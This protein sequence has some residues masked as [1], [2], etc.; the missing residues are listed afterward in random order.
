MKNLLTRIALALLITQGPGVAN[1][2]DAN[3]SESLEIQFLADESAQLRNKA[4]E[5]SGPVQIFEYVRN[6]VEFLPY[7]GAKSGSI[8]TFLG[9][10]GN[11]VDT[12]SVLIAM[13]RSRGIPARYAVGTIRMP[14]TDAANWL[15][16]KNVDLAKSI[17]RDQG[18]QFVTLATDQSTIELEHVWVEALLPFDNYRGESNAD[19]QALCQ[20][21]P[22]GCTWVGLSPS[23]KRHKWVDNP[24]RLH[25][26]LAFD[27]TKYYEAIKNKDDTRRDK[28]PLE[29]YE[30][31]I[32]EYLRA[33]HQ[34]KS[35]DDAIENK[36]I[37]REELGLL[38]ASLPFTTV[39]AIRRYDAMSD[40][41][42]AAPSSERKKWAKTLHVTTGL[43]YGQCSE[44]LGTFDVNL[45]ELATR[46]LTS[47][48][49]L[50]SSASKLQQI[51]RLGGNAIP[52]M[53]FDMGALYAS[54]LSGVFGGTPPENVVYTF[55]CSNDGARLAID[56]SKK[57]SKQTPIKIELR[58]EGPPDPDGGANDMSTTATY[59]GI[60]GGYYLIATGGESS[61]WTQSHRAAE[62]LLNANARY[63]VVFNPSDL[64]NPT[65]QPDTGIDC[66][67][68]IDANGN[69]WDA[70]DKKLMDDTAAQDELT[71]G[72]LY[73]AGTQYFTKM[74]E[75]LAR[76]D[77]LNRVK[78]PI[79]N[80]LGVVSTVDDVEYIDGT[81]FSVLPGG[82]LIDMKGIHIL[83]SWKI[84]D[85]GSFSNKQF[86]L[87]G[88]IGSSL[89]HEIW[90]ELTG[91]DAVSTVRGIQMALANGA[92]LLN[93]KKNAATDNVA[94]EL[95]KMGFS[96][97]VPAGF[98]AVNFDLYGDKPTAWTHA[99]VGKSFEYFR[100]GVS[101][102]TPTYYRTWGTY[103]YST[104]SGLYGWTKCADDY[105]NYFIAN[106]SKYIFGPLSYCDGT[107]L[108]SGSNIFSTGTALLYK[109]EEIWKSPS[110]SLDQ[111]LIELAIGQNVY[112]FFD[113]NKGF[114]VG[115][116]LYRTIPLAADAFPLSN[117]V[118]FR[119]DVLV[120]DVAQSWVEYLI[121]SKLTTGS[122]YRFA[123]DIRKQY[124]SSTGHLASM[125]MAISNNSLTAGG[126][127]VGQGLPSAPRSATEPNPTEGN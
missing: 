96:S 47:G 103:T 116:N 77:S 114:V 106:S 29:I 108:L 30:A 97:S 11:D 41:D 110:F 26:A 80:F 92:T 102:S 115:N 101:A 63:P 74:R 52:G 27:Y 39:S 93:P 10:R 104:N 31:Q 111:S 88:H 5:L 127:Y 121:P 98:A 117:V 61:N 38:P 99:T 79:A 60:A 95:V 105:E 113:R 109:T 13:L 32:L 50:D 25:D 66:I 37:E 71:G 35:I 73:V 49:L 68:Y 87:F 36:G 4:A 21:N 55:V 12:A 76:L 3:L 84:D 118:F 23:F 18:I 100:P 91:Y 34:G 22:S 65:C 17:L 86:E 2:L 33:N 14:A 107:V 40:H 48:V 72:L 75:K 67:P 15:G 9:L 94:G 119:D 19:T 42:A 69:G 45:V 124:E 8:N 81:A 64:A 83:G 59:F 112:D 126:G 51:W 57:F 44:S 85:A 125:G 90:Q 89:E 54:M 58:L 123:V 1:A 122:Q 70:S 78:T 62:Q 6:N 53:T 20:S 24:I 7:H 120:R 56:P 82:L 28:N 43:A 16:V 46:R